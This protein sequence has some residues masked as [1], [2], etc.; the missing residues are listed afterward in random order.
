MSEPVK[1]SIGVAVV[2]VFV[3]VLVYGTYLPYRKSKDYVAAISNTGEATSLQTFLAP[4]IEALDDHSPSGQEE[5]FRNFTQTVAGVLSNV[6]D[7]SENTQLVVRALGATV[8]R[9]ALELVNRQSGTS[10]PQTYYALATTYL[11]VYDITGISS[12]KNR[13]RELLEKGLELSPDRPQFL[14]GLFE[15]EKNYGS[16]EQAEFYGNRILELWP[17]DK[18][19]QRDLKLLNS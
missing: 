13:G 1:R 12:Y 5:T 8:D 3:A 2:L 7:S 11:R 19:T 18:A 10:Q 6:K 17:S 15:Y 9:Y 4:F 14:Y 16:R